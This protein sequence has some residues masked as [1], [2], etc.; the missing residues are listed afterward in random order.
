MSESEAVAAASGAGIARNLGVGRSYGFAGGIVPSLGASKTYQWVDDGAAIVGELLTTQERLLREAVTNGGYLT[1]VYALLPSR[2][3]VVTFEAAVRQA[4]TGTQDVATAVQPRYLDREEQEYIHLHACAFTPATMEET[5][6]GLLEGYRH[7]TLLPPRMLAAFVGPGI[8]EEGPAVLTQ[9]DLPSYAFYG[10]MGLPAYRD[11][12]LVLAHQW[13]VESGKLTN[14]PF[15]LLPDKHFHTSIQGDTGT[16][17]SELAMRLALELAMKFH[18]PVLTFEFGTGWRGLFNS[19]LPR[20]RFELYQLYP[21]APRP[22]RWPL[23]RVPR[24]VDVGT[25]VASLVQILAN[26]AGMGERQISLLQGTLRYLYLQNGV[27]LKNVPKLL[28]NWDTRLARKWQ[29][30]TREEARFVLAAPGAL[31]DALSPDQMQRLVVYRSGRV[32]VTDWINELRILYD[33]INNQSDKQSLSGAINRLER[34]CQGHLEHITGAVQDGEVIPAL[35][36]LPLIGPP[37]DEWGVTVIE[38]GLAFGDNFTKAALFG[39]M[40]WTIYTDLREEVH[41]DGEPR[42]RVEVF[43]EEANKVLVGAEDTD[44]KKQSTPTLFEDMWRD[45]RKAFYLHPITQ[46]ISALSSSILASC[47]NSYFFQSKDPADVDQILPH[48]AKSPKGVHD[49]P[50]VH[51]VSRLEVG[52]CVVRRG[53]SKEKEEIEMSLIRPRMVARHLPN[54]ETLRRWY[55]AQALALWGNIA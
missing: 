5:V 4:F 9:E 39:L 37:G 2:E 20:D 27:P 47:G 46:T 31:I 22:L 40:L 51:H 1:D 44:G 16:G 23:L 43:I 15:V 3:A 36:E 50:Y 8:F 35:E 34:L 17:K 14:T 30:V 25:Y 53:L 19:P 32:G 11:R 10:E 52:A 12:G 13:S 33:K 24:R 41:T 54:D 6:P 42:Y 29:H 26:A 28:R 21:G 18:R 7:T 48:V 45:S 55:Q 49:L 38:G